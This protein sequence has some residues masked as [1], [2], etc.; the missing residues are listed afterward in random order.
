MHIGYDWCYRLFYYSFLD[1]K[2]RCDLLPV[3]LDPAPPPTSTDLSSHE[4]VKV[5]IHQNQ[6]QNATSSPSV[7]LSLLISIHALVPIPLD[8]QSSE[9][10]HVYGTVGKVPF[11]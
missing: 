7:E 10:R 3:L 8:I 1:V 11:C 5:L 6:D 9:V 2:T 4:N